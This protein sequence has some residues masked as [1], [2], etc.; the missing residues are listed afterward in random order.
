VKVQDVSLRLFR[1]SEI[2]L[3]GAAVLAVAEVL[4]LAPSVRGRVYSL[5]S[6]VKQ[7]EKSNAVGAV[8]LENINRP[9]KDEIIE[10]CY[11]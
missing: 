7:P 8:V 5:V 4:G 10:S 3:T 2:S 1:A 6:S 9:D 11:R